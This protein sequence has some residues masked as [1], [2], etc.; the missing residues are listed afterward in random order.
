MLLAAEY[1]NI[2]MTLIPGVKGETIHDKA[3]PAGTPVTVAE[4]GSWRAHANAWKHLLESDKQTALIL[5]DDVDWDVD[6]R[7]AAETLAGVL[8]Q[9]NHALRFRDPVEGEEQTPYGLDWDVLWL[10]A[11]IHE[12]HPKL[13]K[14]FIQYDDPLAPPAEF[15]SKSFKEHFQIRGLQYPEQG[16]KRIIVPAYKPICI[17]SYAVTRKGT[18]FIKGQ[19]PNGNQSRL[20]QFLQ[21]HPNCFCNLV[22][23]GFPRPQTSQ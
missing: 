20:T 17:W 12:S 15:I 4:L 2:S 14:K 18:Y 3:K 1:S 13:K 16:G 10:A 22:R 23:R 19:N 8:N 5:E 21:E 11:C 7:T 9:G 6:I